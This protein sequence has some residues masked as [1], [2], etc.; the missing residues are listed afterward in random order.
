MAEEERRNG[1]GWTDGEGRREM[2]RNRE[3]DGEE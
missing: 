2:E 1:D 3:M